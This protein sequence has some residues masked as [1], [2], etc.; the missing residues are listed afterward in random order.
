MLVLKWPLDATIS[1]R[2]CQETNKF[3]KTSFTFDRNG[4]NRHIYVAFLKFPMFFTLYSFSCML[5][6]V[7]QPY[8]N[9]EIMLC[10]LTQSCWHTCFWCVLLFLFRPLCS[11]LLSSCIRRWFCNQRRWSSGTK[12]FPSARWQLWHIFPNLSALLNIFRCWVA[13]CQSLTVLSASSTGPSEG[14]RQH[15]RIIWCL[16]WSS[17]GSCVCEVHQHTA[18]SN[19]WL[20]LICH[21]FFPLSAFLSYSHAVCRQ[22]IR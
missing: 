21:L 2:L 19:M 5:F 20:F 4:E 11:V 3:G 15:S 18:G 8:H 14:W 7:L 1:T 10:F 16:L 12:L 9:S 13:L 17:R 22:E 6:W